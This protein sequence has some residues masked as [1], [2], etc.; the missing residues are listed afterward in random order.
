MERE[1][2]EEENGFEINICP[3][4]SNGIFQLT[5]DNVQFPKAEIE[6]YNMLGELVYFSELRTPNSR[7][8]LSSLPSGIYFVRITTKD[9]IVSRK[10]VK[11]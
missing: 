11:E 1:K 2:K 6:V 9:G 4:H 7:L 5:I 8:D 3:S 10:I